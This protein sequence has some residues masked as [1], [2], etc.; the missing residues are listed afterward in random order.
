M[1]NNNNKKTNYHFYYEFE[2]DAENLNKLVYVLKEE[3]IKFDKYDLENRTSIEFKT[4]NE[5]IL[6]YLKL[7][8]KEQ[9]TWK[10]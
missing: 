9:F 6:T 10:S 7:A 2:K 8:H 5:K 3:K 1:D 4:S